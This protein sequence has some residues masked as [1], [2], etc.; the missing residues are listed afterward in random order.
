MD[1][2]DEATQRTRLRLGIL[3]PLWASRDGVEVGLGGRRQQAVVAVLLV[4]RGH[5]VS[6]ERLLDTLWDGTPP[7]SGAASLQSYV[8]HLRRALEPH[9]APRTPSRV[10]V[11]RGSGYALV[12]DEDDVDAWRFEDL[13]AQA[14]EASEPGTR[15]GLLRE[16]L[17]LWRGPVLAE[18]AGK[19]W[20]DTEARRLGELRDV[21]REQLLTARLDTGEAAVVV[22][23]A[24]RLLA[25]EPLREER[26]RILALALYRSHRQADALDAL[27]R[28]RKLLA[29]EL[30]VD[31][32]PA[33]R[34]LEAEVLAQSPTLD[35]PVPV[36]AAVPVPVP[37]PRQRTPADRPELV[38][39]EAELGQLLTCLGLALEGVPR[40]AV[41][42]G[43]AGIGKTSLLHQVRDDAREAGATVLSARGSQL[44]KEF[45]LGAVRQLFDPVLT[46]AAARADLLNGAAVGAAQVFDA[47]YTPV[48]GPTESLFTILHGLYWLTSNLASRGPVVIAVDDVQWCDTTSLRFLGYLA[49]RLE[50]LPVL[51]VAT[52]RTGEQYADDELLYELTVGPDAVSVQPAPLTARGTAELVRGRL[53]G[54]DDVFAAACFRTTSGNPLLLRQLLR[55]L[56]AEGVRPDASHADTVRAI[57]SRAV[58][59]MVLMRF[60]RMPEGNREVARAVA[61]LGDGASLPMVT[62]MTGLSEAA[63]AAATASLARSEVLRPEHPLGFVHPLVE[64][65]VY[66]DL[67]L[68]ER[69]M[70]HARAAH[71]LAATGASAE[72][73]AAHLLAVPPRGDTGVVVLLREAAR[74]AGARGSTDSATAYLRRALLEPPAADDRPDLLMELGRL[75]AVVDGL[76]AIE[77]LTAA[78]RTHPDPT[79]RAE[80]AIMLA[81]TAVFASDRGNATRIAHAALQDLTP[82]LV[83]ERQALAGLERISA[84]MHGLADYDAG[85][86]PDV[87][88]TG[89]GARA[90]AAALAW[91]ELCRGEDRER[92]VGLARFALEDRILQDADPGLLWVVAAMVLGMSGEDTTGFWEDELQHAYRTGG[93]FAALAVHL[94][95]GYVQWQHGDLPDA[96][97]SMVQCTEQNELWG[98]NHAIGQSYADA[99]MICMLLDRGSLEE[100]QRVVELAQDGFRIGDGA[101]LFTEARAKVAHTRGDHE[102]AL[103]T[104][105]SVAAEMAVM[106]NPVWRPWRSMR[107]RVLARL[108]RLEEAVDL[109][110]E[111]L[112]LARRWGA[113][114]LVG[115]TLLVLGDLLG[116]AGEESTGLVEEAVALL[117]TTRNRLDLARGLSMLGARVASTDPDRARTLLRRALDLA[118]T[119]TADALRTSISARLAELGVDV[120]PTPRQRAALTAS[121]RRIAELAADGA[122]FQEI[123][124]SLFVTTRTVTT[125]VG[126]VSERL[127]AATPHELRAALDRLPTVSSQRQVTS[128]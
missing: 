95:L 43:P 62:A 9:R 100:A 114:A 41:I 101:R 97:Q 14:A 80:A 64:A 40:V 45:G 115:K 56:E 122:A 54:A 15:A 110:T 105:E 67:P 66:D 8:S 117:E 127:G 47:T 58:S 59:S 10:L 65:A 89:A 76:A 11:S 90:L 57:G 13:V 33:L 38:D 120:P 2:S 92:A 116:Q 109:V 25:E 18:Y 61:V 69:E 72:Q 19:A 78:Y 24:E 51:L 17:A 99:F 107:A 21:A 48:D 112:A 73:V 1:L 118:E 102:Q 31:P 83:D 75:E 36:T 70:A 113:P 49:R 128:K 34:A 4:A 71:V 121:E 111:E 39:R 52:W 123:A 124:Q 27:R 77:H 55:A 30:G 88:G 96:L 23:E 44:E 22:A 60:R 106:D 125:I 93:L 53:D 32:G 74:R 86:A 103:A 6:A 87:V 37:V 16:A 126:S 85:P 84:Y 12:V 63:T 42:E 26:W 94:W 79:R 7:P 28:A 20:A 50:G 3:G 46:D 35:A 91:E 108:D 68:G 29:D 104:L 119:C 98:S 81:R 82:D 5:Q